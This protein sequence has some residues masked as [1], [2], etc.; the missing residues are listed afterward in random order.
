MSLRFAAV[1]LLTALAACS[2]NETANPTSVPTDPRVDATIANMTSRYDALL[3]TCDH[4][5]LFALAYLRTTEE[6]RSAA[7]EPGFFH[8]P[9]YLNDEDTLFA[10]YYFDHIDHWTQGEI[11]T[12]PAAWSIAF[13]ASDDRSVSTLGDAILGISAHINQDLPFVLATLG[14]RDAQGNSRKADHDKVNVFL[15]R[16]SFTEDIR[17]HWDATYDVDYQTGLPT[18]EA[19]REQAWQSAETLVDA[20]TPEARAKAEA[21]IASNAEQTATALFALSKYMNGDSSATRDAYCAS[22]R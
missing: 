3:A 5:G 11:D 17:E 4:K 10:K 7:A 18:I 14:L 21:D 12:V 8:D 19:W 15:A 2:A 20:T 16:V 13:Q 9:A 6:Y 1:L 22:R